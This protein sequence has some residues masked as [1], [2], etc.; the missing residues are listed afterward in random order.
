[1]KYFVYTVIGIVVAAIIAG[2]FIVG[3]PKEERLR[4]F[5]E[6]RVQ[7][8]Q[9]LQSEIINY[10]LT[11]SRL[12]ENVFALRDDIRGVAIP[13][14]PQTGDEYR[15][16]VKG[17]LTFSLCASFARPSVAPPGVP[18]PVRPIEPSYFGEENWQHGAGFICFER[19]IDPERYRPREPEPKV[20]R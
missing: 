18:K 6:R 8:L 1:M 11:K 17:S 19:T 15:Y 9:F 3:S 12:P 7:D 4:R 13:R 20:P 14:D 2:F 16:E 10:W 5:D